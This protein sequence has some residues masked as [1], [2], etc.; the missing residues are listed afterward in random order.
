MEDEREILTPLAGL[1]RRAEHGGAQV[2]PGSVPTRALFTWGDPLF[3]AARKV[4]HAKP[5]DLKAGVAQLHRGSWGGQPFVLVNPGMGGPAAAIVAD[6]LQA[7]GVDTIV[8]IGFAGIL[9]PLLQSGDIVVVE[10]AIGED[11]TS[12]SYL[13]G[14]Q[15]GGEP[16]VVEA[17]PIVKDAL[18]LALANEPGATYQCGTVWTTDTPYRETVRKAKAYRARGAHAVEME[19]AALLAVAKRRGFRAG[20]AVVLSDS[21]N[22]VAPLDAQVPAGSDGL[23][24]MW[25]PAPTGSLDG[26][27]EALVRGALPVVVGPLQAPAR[28]V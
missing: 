25:T 1:K 15:E 2:A 18:E 9:H 7:C 8:G 20:A 17:T 24:W 4:S 13:D 22:R 12:K 16:D 23:E 10:R 21:L 27:V 6:K 19:T 5:L 3:D 26:K 11:G 14:L 28:V